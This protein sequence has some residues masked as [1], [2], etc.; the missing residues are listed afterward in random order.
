MTWN[1]KGPISPANTWI[2]HELPSDPAVSAD[3][4]RLDVLQCGAGTSTNMNAN[5]VIANRYFDEY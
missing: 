4:F 5:E 1:N 3:E 2:E